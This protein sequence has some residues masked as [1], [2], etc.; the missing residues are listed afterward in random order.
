MRLTPRQAA[1][2]QPLIAEQKVIEARITSTI[3]AF[4][5]SFNQDPNRWDG[6]VDIDDTGVISLLLKEPDAAP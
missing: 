4:L 6:R 2:L 1:M 3:R 5:V